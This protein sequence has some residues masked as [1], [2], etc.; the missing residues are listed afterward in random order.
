MAT[1]TKAKS[2]ADELTYSADDVVVGFGGAVTF[3]PAAAAAT[4]AALNDAGDLGSMQPDDAAA[5]VQRAIFEATGDDDNRGGLRV[6]IDTC[7]AALTA[8]HV[9]AGLRGSTVGFT[10][11][12]GAARAS[13]GG[14]DGGSSSSGQ[15]GGTAAG[16]GGASQGAGAGSGGDPDGGK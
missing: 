1:K 11:Q 7:L 15:G 9:R 3:S 16:A 12:P 2:S 10:D 6:S 14:A 5:A 13:S 8:M 4:A